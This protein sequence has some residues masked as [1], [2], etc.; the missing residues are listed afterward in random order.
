MLA[1]GSTRSLTFDGLT[2]EA[3]SG[4]V[5]SEAVQDVGLSTG[6]YEVSGMLT[7]ERLIEA[8]LAAG[9]Y[10]GARVEVHLVNWEDPQ[11][12]VHLRTGFLGEITMGGG[13]FRAEIRS[14]ASQFEEPQGR[15]FSRYC[16]AE[17]GDH[18]CGVD[19]SA[20]NFR[21]E[22][23][24]STVIDRSQFE[25][26]GLSGLDDGWFV[27]G[28]VEWLSGVNVGQKH[29]VARFVSGEVSQVTLRQRPAYTPVEGDT[30]RISAGCDKS[31]ETCRAKFSNVI[32]FR[33]FPHMPG[34][35]FALSY[36]T[37]DSGRNDGRPI[38]G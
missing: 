7:S 21:R 25:V 10:S 19:L 34:N 15:V 30:F 29:V 35:D 8:E 33:G 12:R 1:R 18:R 6:D 32:N 9:L 16:D 37:R 24:V 3:A 14:L 23:T 26:T 4:L 28:R 2:Y 38:V 22:G 31:V 27:F 36:P 20:G 13:A 11:Q 5:G 17:V